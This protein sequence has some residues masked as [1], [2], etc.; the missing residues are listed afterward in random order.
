MRKKAGLFGPKVKN[1]GDEEEITDEQ[2]ESY[3]DFTKS[4]YQTLLLDFDRRGY[5]QAVASSAHDDERVG[6][7]LGRYIGRPT[8][9][10][11]VLTR[12]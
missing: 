6:S 5:E 2:E 9:H 4:V 10:T 8:D 11:V 7:M 12:S 1:D 3:E